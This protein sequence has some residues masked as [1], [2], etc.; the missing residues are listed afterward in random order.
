MKRK[1][2]VEP[3]WLTTPFPFSLNMKD[4]IK[5]TRKNKRKENEKNNTNNIKYR[6][7]NHIQSKNKETRKMKEKV[8]NKKILAYDN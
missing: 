2:K 8:E 6:C 7:G 4:K 5:I 3:K 1:T